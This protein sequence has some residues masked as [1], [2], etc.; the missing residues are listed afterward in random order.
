MATW[1]NGLF[2]VDMNKEEVSRL[3]DTEDYFTNNC[4]LRMP[5]SRI[6]CKTDDTH[7]IIIKGT[8]I[9]KKFEIE[10]K[11]TDIKKLDPENCLICAKNHIYR[12]N[13]KDKKVKKISLFNQLSE[14]VRESS[15]T[16]N[17]FA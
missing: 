14:F 8:N 15:N 1:N 4:I 5:G 7:F 3:C 13:V 11:I 17:I 9:V 2:F 10:G 12:L 6:V 16:R